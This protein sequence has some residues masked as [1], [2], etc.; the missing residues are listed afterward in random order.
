MTAVKVGDKV[1]PKGTQYSATVCSM[2]GGLVVFTWDDIGGYGRMHEDQL[3]PT[4]GP[5]TE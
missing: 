4:V 5:T 3:E 2:Y 1:R